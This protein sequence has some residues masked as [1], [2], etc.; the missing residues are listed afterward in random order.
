MTGVHVHILV[1][2]NLQKIPDRTLRL[3]L[4]L[5]DFRRHD[6]GHPTLCTLPEAEM[7]PGFLRYPSYGTRQYCFLECSR[8]HAPPSPRWR[9]W[10][11]LSAE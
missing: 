5:D 11:H 2:G 6:P 8:E 10:L 9:A 1:T 4:D 7:D 3:L